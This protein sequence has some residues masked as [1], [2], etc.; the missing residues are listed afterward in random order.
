MSRRRLG[1]LLALL[2]PLPLLSPV[3]CHPSP[4]VL[5]FLFPV[6]GPLSAAVTRPPVVVVQGDFLGA[7]GGDLRADAEKYARG[8]RQALAAA[9]VEFETSKDS[10]VEQW[11]LPPTCRVALLP[12]NRAVSAT[13]LSKLLAFVGR[14]GK[15][16]AFYVGPDALLSAAG[17]RGGEV[18]GATRPDQFAVMRLAGDTLPLLPDA[19]TQSSWNVCR[20]EPLPGSVVIATWAEASGTDTG[21]PAVV[22]GEKGAFISHVLVPGDDY[23]KGRLLRALV[24][25]FAPEILPGVAQ[26]ELAQ[27]DAVGRFG[28]LDRLAEYLQRRR[29]LG[30][31]VD[32]P[33][34]AASEARSLRDAARRALAEGNAVTAVEASTSARLAAA[35]AYY[36]AYP[37]KPGELRGAWMIYCGRPTWDETMRQLHEANFNAVMPRFCSAGVAYFP[38]A[39]LPL[40][41][42]AKENGDQLAAA[43]A[44]A[45]K[46]GIALHA[47]TVA[48]F[49]YEAPP[50]VREAYAKAGR[51]MVSAAG[52][53]TSWLCPSNPENRKLV[54]GACLEMASRYPVAG[55]QLDYIRYPW[56]D[57]CFC[58]TCKTKFQR[59][60]GVR[61]DQ[62]PFDCLEGKYRGR[63][64]DW[65]REQITSLVREISLRARDARPG[66]QVSGDVFVNWETHRDSFGQDWKAWVDE[67]LLDFVCPMDY[68]PDDETFATWVTRQRGWVSDRV[69]LCV[70][71]GPRVEDCNLTPEHVVRQVELSRKL[72]GDGFVLFEYDEGLAADHLPVLASGLCSEPSRFSPGPPHLRATASP[73][74]AGVQ[75]TACLA[76]HR[77][78]PP[79]APAADVGGP[80]ALSDLPQ[81][82]ITSADLKLYTTDAWPVLELGPLTADTPVSRD[83]RLA[84]GSYRLLAEGTLVRA[85][86]RADERFARWSLPF[87]V[88]G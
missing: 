63:F 41:D 21:L 17:V 73:T 59:D 12:Y 45:A 3:P 15:V 23:E 46:Y 88:A 32:V 87:R 39:Y 86:G 14:G 13:E 9:C 36:A 26:R 67:G 51:L 5:P 40:G 55:I 37:A 71:I 38:S 19:V 68:T 16:I 30:Q 11:G 33:L 28:T 47:R 76:T 35:K 64:A 52:E 60:L 83:V 18:V 31:R 25:H 84:P 1:V 20:C 50:G 78:A 72:G 61:V 42:Y 69:P 8:V 43:A 70:G 82:V 27:L 56:K 29:D 34:G 49:I 66:I 44:A 58:P 85:G 7:D 80:I 22:L 53:T 10:T 2:G 6:P 62:W 24:A 77:D 54:V 79:K 74:A 48:L 57:Y 81:V 4:A 65:R 75:V